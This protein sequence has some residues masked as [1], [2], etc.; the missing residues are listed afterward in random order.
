VVGGALL[1]VL[2]SGTLAASVPGLWIVAAL[3]AAGLAIGVRR[4]YALFVRG[5]RLGPGWRA[6]LGHLAAAAV[7][8]GLAGALAGALRLTLAAASPAAGGVPAAFWSEVATAAS[9]AA[10]GLGGGL[11]LALFWLLLRVRAEAVIRARTELRETLD[12]GGGPAGKTDR[13][14]GG[15]GRAP[16]SDAAVV[17]RRETGR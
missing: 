4:G 10:L 9:V 8:T 6:R 16:G 13:G 12:A 2:R 1:G 17:H 3:A 11:L 15:R 7:G 14:I 5:D